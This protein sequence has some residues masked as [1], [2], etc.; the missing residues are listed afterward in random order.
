MLC[1][2][3]LKNILP[4]KIFLLLLIALLYSFI[5]NL[6]NKSKFTK[7]TI[8]YGYIYDYNINDNKLTIKLH[9]KENIVCNYY[10]YNETKLPELK[11]GDYIKLGG[12][13][14][15]PNKNTNFN[16]FNYRKYL[17][18]EHINYIFNITKIEKI[19][20]NNKLKYKLKNI[21]IKKIDNNEN[22]TY[23][24]T[25]LLGN[26]NYID[27]NVLESYRINGISHLFAISGMHISLISLIILKIFN[28]FKFKN[29]LVTIIII[30]YMFLTNFSPSIMRAGIFFILLLINKKLNLN[31][32]NIGIML[33]LLSICI[34][35]DPYIIYKIGF[36]YSYIITFNLILF[37]DIIKRNKN[38]T[39]K[40]LIISCIAFITSLP[41]TINNFYQINLFG[42]ILNLFYVPLITALIF[43]ITLIDF[44]IP[45]PF[46]KY[47]FLILEKSSLYFSNFKYLIIT[48]PKLNMFLIIMYY[49]L[50]LYILYNIKIKKYKKIF[51]LL[52]VLFIYKNFPYL[53]NNFELTFFD[54]AQGD[55]IFLKLPYNKSN[56]LIDT[57]GSKSYTNIS[58][59]IIINYLKS[60]GVN[61]LDYIILTHGDYDHMGETINLVENFKV[62]KVIINCGPYNELEKELIK[63]LDKK[64]IK[65]YSCIKELNIDKSKLYFLQ[66]K[67]YDNENDNSN[68]IY[69]ELDGYKF[70]FMGDAS[71]TT[72]KEILSKYNLSNIDVLKVGHHGS[73]TS[74]SKEF[75]NKVS[76]EY[77]II[78][79]G[80]NNRYG[81]PNKEVLDNL[82]NSKIYRT[83]VDGSIMFKIKNNKLKI[84]TCIP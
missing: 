57:G 50:I 59:Q 16:S 8:I 15:I 52:I 5:Y 41:I 27:K 51:I 74:S 81:H 45:L 65:Y 54:V 38:K 60:I 64:K 83:D 56:I 82:K 25:F 35:I 12:S 36:Q 66:T 72:E 21:I 75:I 28:K 69:T 30:F 42:I 61:K 76:P 9:S 63:V 17:K 1:L 3:R 49:I 32:N 14:T 33:I 11:L 55:S 70:M 29:I 71:S 34:L 24:Y 40:L 6:N 26:N 20:D 77:S 73:K 39:I 53:N 48:F 19:K 78:S 31:I 43:P 7:E 67:E 44:I 79:V 84:E 46:I 37:S 80:K 2:K 4:Y 10:F 18:Y 47:I 23:L 22:K 58:K 62:K 13:L 68:V